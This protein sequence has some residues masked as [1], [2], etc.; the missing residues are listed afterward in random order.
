MRFDASLQTCLFVP[1]GPS[2]KQF[3]KDKKQCYLTSA[4]TLLNAHS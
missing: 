4:L 2:P 1:E 3:Q